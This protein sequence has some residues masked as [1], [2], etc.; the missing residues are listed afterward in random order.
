MLENEGK[1]AN[2]PFRSWVSP[3]RHYMHDALSYAFTQAI[4]RLAAQP[5]G[6]VDLSIAVRKEPWLRSTAL[7]HLRSDAIAQEDADKI[8]V[9]VREA[10]PPSA[11]KQS[12]LCREVKRALT[13]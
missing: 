13:K 1:P 7:K 5:K 9:N 12:E 6:V 4:A 10:C 2:P 8:I 3:G 11:A